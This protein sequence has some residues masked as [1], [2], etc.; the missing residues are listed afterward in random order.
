MKSASRTASRKP[1]KSVNAKGFIQFQSKG[2]GFGAV[3]AKNCHS[4]ATTKIARAMYC[5]A[6]RMFWIRSPISTLRQGYPGSPPR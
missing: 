4:A 3:P 1:W 6:S 5:T 2:V